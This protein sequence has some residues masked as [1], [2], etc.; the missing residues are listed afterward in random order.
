MRKWKNNWLASLCIAGVLALMPSISVCAE[1]E[2]ESNDDLEHAQELEVNTEMVGNLSSEKDR[3]F[4]KITLSEPGMVNYTFKTDNESGQYYYVVFCDE[5][6]KEMI[7]SQRLYGSPGNSYTSI[8]MGLSEGTYYARVYWELF[9]NNGFSKKNYHLTVNYE[10]VDDWE[11]EY[12]EDFES[13]TP[14]KL[15]TDIKGNLRFDSEKDYYKFTIEGDGKFS[16]TFRM[17]NQEGKYCSVNLYDENGKELIDEQRLY[18]TPG[19]SFTSAHIGLTKGTYYM[20]VHWVLKTNNG[21]STDDYHLTLNFEKANDWEVEYNEDF[22]HAN[23][24]KPGSEVFGSIR[25]SQ[26]V[27]MY[28]FTLYDRRGINVMFRHKSLESK[29]AYW[30]V[31]LYDKDG[32]ELAKYDVAGD[33][34]NQQKLGSINLAAGEYYVKVTQYNESVSRS[35]DID[36][37]LEIGTGELDSDGGFRDMVKEGLQYFY[38]QVGI[39]P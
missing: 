13:A 22:D 37:G 19:N 29:D 39:R 2:Q 36:Y 27:D 38:K 16:Y 15:N 18:G 24:I 7:S 23:M 35:S 17:E 5:N 4:Y 14:I 26:D 9:T 11:K 34:I 31:R 1:S 8:N 28:R 20:R 10:E 3:D 21:F 6:G 25:Q 33:L 32:N 12:N 30:Q